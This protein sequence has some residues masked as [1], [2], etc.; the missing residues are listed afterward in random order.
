[1]KIL[2]AIFAVLAASCTSRPPQ[3]APRLRLDGY[4]SLDTSF[5]L[6]A[7]GSFG[8]VLE[9]YSCGSATCRRS[10][11]NQSAEGSAI[12]VLNWDIGTE[13]ARSLGKLAAAAAA[14]PASSALLDGAALV[15]HV[16]DSSWNIAGSPPNRDWGDSLQAHLI[17]TALSKGRGWQDSLVVVSMGDARSTTVRLASGRD[18]RTELGTSDLQVICESA[19][20]PGPGELAGTFVPDRWDTLPPLCG[21]ALLRGET[22]AFARPERPRGFRLVARGR[23]PHLGCKGGEFALGSGWIWK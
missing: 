21:K 6:E 11:L 7:V 10:I 18:R 15:L 9:S 22:C 3:A 19:A 13:E 20:P 16:G 17:R 5:C 2:I 23:S 4:A 14:N 1:M 12:G 8:S